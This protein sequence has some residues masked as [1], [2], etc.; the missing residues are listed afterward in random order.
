[1]SL[2]VCK[3]FAT[4]AC[5]AI[6]AFPAAVLA[7]EDAPGPSLFTGDL[8][9]IIWSLVTFGVVLLV[10]GKFAWKPILAALRKR[11]EFIRESLAAAKRERQEAEARLREYSDKIA[12]AKAEA[13]AIV[14][15]G[16]RDADVLRAKLEADAKREAAAIL[17]RAKRD[18]TIAKNTAIKELYTVSSRL[19]VDLASRVIGKE[20]KA[21]DHARLIADSIEELT[22]AGAK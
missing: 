4:P 22:G 3:L 12:A 19:A 18:L 5:V 10:L 14:E 13:S 1:M 21:E 8:G 11:E 15:E 16:R 9:N 17:E 6:G 20:L 7:S 2:D